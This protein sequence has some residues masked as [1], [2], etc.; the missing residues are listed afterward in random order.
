MK[1]IVSTQNGI[2]KMADGSSSFSINDVI[3]HGITAFVTDYY[4]VRLMILSH[5]NYNFRELLCNYKHFVH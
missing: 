2:F 5:F 1:Y 3:M 4:C